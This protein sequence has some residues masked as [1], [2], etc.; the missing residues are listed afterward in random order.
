MAE[1]RTVGAERR[2][3]QRISCAIPCEVHGTG[4]PSRGTVRNVSAAGMSVLVDMRVAQGDVVNVTLQSG[5]KQEMLVEAIVWHDRQVRIRRTGETIRRLGL[6]LSNA[7]DAYRELLEAKEPAPSAS[8]SPSYAK[9]G[10]GKKTKL[11]SPKTIRDARP[12]SAS[13]SKSKAPPAPEQLG[14]PKPQRFRVRVKQETNPR[15]R[16]ILVFAQ[17]EDEARTSALAETGSGWMILEIER[18]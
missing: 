17:S 15:S 6:V 10:S 12:A 13:T 8:P 1:S 9:D 7:P 14:L 5:N 16:S 4:K 3:H 18:A 2:K 11:R